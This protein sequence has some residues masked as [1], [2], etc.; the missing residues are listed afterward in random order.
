MSFVKADLQSQSQ[1]ASDV[2]QSMC[3]AHGCPNRWS[4]SDNN[5]KLCRWHRYA[6]PQDWPTV[7]SQLRLGLAPKEPSAMRPR[8]PLSDERKRLLEEFR[9]MVRADKVLNNDWA[10]R[11][12]AREEA[13]ETLSL[14]Q[15]E[16]WRQALRHRDDQE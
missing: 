9:Q 14:A 8:P 5:G 12:K 15:K 2:D 3:Q 6:E 16:L 10:Y 1:D 11:L 4:L 13:G 7:T